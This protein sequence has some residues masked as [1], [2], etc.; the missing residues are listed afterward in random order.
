MGITSPAETLSALWRRIPPRVVLVARWTF[1]GF[2]LVAWLYWAWAA[3]RGENWT[4]GIAVVITAVIFIPR[5]LLD[6]RNG[7][8]VKRVESNPKPVDWGVPP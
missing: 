5:S 2:L 7:L 8:K 3:Y 6:I 4:N 1:A